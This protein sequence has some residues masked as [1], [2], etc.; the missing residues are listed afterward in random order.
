M[1]IDNQ[2][3][4][5]PCGLTIPKHFEIHYRCIDQGRIKRRGF[6]GEIKFYLEDICSKLFLN[7]SISNDLKCIEKIQEDFP[8][9]CPTTICQYGIS[10]NT[11]KEFKIK[12]IYLD[13]NQI[14]GF[15]EK[16]C[17]EENLQGFHWAQTAVNKGQSLSCPSPCTGMNKNS[18]YYKL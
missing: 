13:N 11:L 1:L 18:I 2:I 12:F 10:K 6:C 17:P 4:N 7:C 15:T 3:F 9:Q 14:I 5:D 16:F 8:C